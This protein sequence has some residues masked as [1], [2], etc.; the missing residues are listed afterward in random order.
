[1]VN[2][3]GQRHPKGWQRVRHVVLQRDSYTCQLRHAVC[4]DEANE[5]HH[6][7]S[8]A[9]L[10][11][12]R[13]EAP[14]DPDACIAVCSACHRVET[15]RQ[16]VEARHAKAQRRPPTHPADGVGRVPPGGTSQPAVHSVCRST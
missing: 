10:G 12:A 2:R 3:W 11:F 8:I 4:T 7:E 13:D 1:M 15:Q 14:I 5:V 16:S 9:A 6:I